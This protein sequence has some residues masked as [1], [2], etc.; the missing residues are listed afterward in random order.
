MRKLLIH[1]NSEL[2][3]LAAQTPEPLIKKSRKSKKTLAT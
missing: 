1:M 2:K 3:K